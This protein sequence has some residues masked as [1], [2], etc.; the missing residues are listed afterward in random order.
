[1][2]VRRGIAIPRGG[3]TAAEGVGDRA[4]KLLEDSLGGTTERQKHHAE[5]V[6][7]SHEKNRAEIQRHVRT[8]N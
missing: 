6:S 2:A 8:Y 5:A 4:L 3:I 7:N 1:M